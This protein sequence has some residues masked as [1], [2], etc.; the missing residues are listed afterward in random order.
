LKICCF[1]S[2]GGFSISHFSG[3]SHVNAVIGIS[4]AIKSTINIC[5]APIDSGIPRTPQTSKLGNTA[6]NSHP[7]EPTAAIADFFMFWKI[8]LHSFIA[9]T[10]V[11][12]LSSSNT[13]SDASLATSVH[14]F[15]MAT[16]IFAILSAGASLIPS[17][18]TATILPL[19]LRRETILS[20]SSGDVLQK[21]THSCCISFKSWI[22]DC[23]LIFSQVIIKR[24]EFCLIS[25]I[26][27]PMAFA[28]NSESPVIMIIFICA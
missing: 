22:S 11:P 7:F 23:S 21:I 8:I 3:G 1:T 9:Y 14:I 17:H 26:V 24:S 18:V 2:L 5:T 6:N 27:C 25:P 15:P 28:V 19:A 13:I 4:S 12:K 16:Q 10:S 20:L